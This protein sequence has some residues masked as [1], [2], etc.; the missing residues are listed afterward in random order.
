MKNKIILY[1]NGCPRCQILKSKLDAANIKYE[2]VDKIDDI[3]KQGYG[4]VPI[5]VVDKLE[6]DFANA[7]QWLRDEDWNNEN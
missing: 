5:L 2:V 4:Q 6:M 3:I 7:I 1:T